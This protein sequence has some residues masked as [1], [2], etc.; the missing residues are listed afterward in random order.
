[1]YLVVLEEGKDVQCYNKSVEVRG[2]AFGLLVGKFGFLRP[3]RLSLQKPAAILHKAR[4]FDAKDDK[5]VQ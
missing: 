2:G 1:M 5:P 4:T 3:A